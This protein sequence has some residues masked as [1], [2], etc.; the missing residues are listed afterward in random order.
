MAMSL[1]V[2]RGDDEDRRS[3]DGVSQVERVE[4]ARRFLWW[5]FPL[6]KLSGTLIA[7]RLFYVGITRAREKLT[8]CEPA[9]YMHVDIIPVRR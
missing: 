9:S 3:F 7:I 8:L 2:H 4:Q 5:L 1:P 6:V